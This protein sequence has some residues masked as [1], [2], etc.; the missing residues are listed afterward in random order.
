MIFVS[1][2]ARNLCERCSCFEIRMA[3]YEMVISN[4]GFNPW[5]E[6]LHLEEV[7]INNFEDFVDA[8]PNLEEVTLLNLV[9]FDCTWMVELTKK[10]IHIYGN[11]CKGG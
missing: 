2:D 9:R 10:G 8:F 4:F 11:M 1:L 7:E 6:I 5:I 3:C